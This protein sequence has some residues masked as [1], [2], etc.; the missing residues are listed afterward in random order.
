MK[1]KIQQNPW[2]TLH[3][4]DKIA[5]KC[6]SE[7]KL[8]E[9]HHRI[10]TIHKNRKKSSKFEI[11]STKWVTTT[12][13]QL[14]DDDAASVQ[15][16]WMLPPSLSRQIWLL[17]ASV[18]YRVSFVMS[19]HVP[20]ISSAIHHFSSADQSPRQIRVSANTSSMRNFF[21]NIS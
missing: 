8:K 9:F 7:F 15:P 20:I 12:T 18:P 21:L 10:A 3:K 2:N 16:S 5:T 14:D 17:V 11:E 13:S 6:T 1:V 4:I 19:T